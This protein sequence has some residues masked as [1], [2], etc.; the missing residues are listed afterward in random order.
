MNIVCLDTASRH[1][2]QRF[3][4]FPFQLYRHTPQW[5]PPFAS[6]AKRMIDRKRHPFYQHSAAEFF[7]A[8]EADRV[9]G[10]LAVLDHCPYNEWNHSQTAFVYLFES[11]NK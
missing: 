10:R 4:D 8:V 7:I 1:D 6:D 11:E 3:L 9:V 5:V 2:V